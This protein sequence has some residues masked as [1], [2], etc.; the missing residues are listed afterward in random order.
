[1][2]L[3][4]ECVVKIDIYAIYMLMKTDMSDFYVFGIFE[5]FR[6]HLLIKFGMWDDYEY[7]FF[8]LLNK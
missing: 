2:L 7:F 3:L 8:V 6:D 4:N 1:M 5:L